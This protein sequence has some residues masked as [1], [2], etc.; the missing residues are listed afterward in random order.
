M[1]QKIQDFLVLIFGNKKKKK[2]KVK[3]KGNKLL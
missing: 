1:S 3:R 2:N